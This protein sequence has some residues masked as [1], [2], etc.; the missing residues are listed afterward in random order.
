[1]NKEEKELLYKKAV[2]TWGT[3]SQVYMVFEECAELIN[4]LCKYN[5]NRATVDDIATE[6]ADVIIM[7]EQLK[8]TIGADKVEAEIDKKLERLK[9]RLNV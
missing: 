6:V 4:S 2:D 3:T 9:K 5:R 1:M 8:F 7:C